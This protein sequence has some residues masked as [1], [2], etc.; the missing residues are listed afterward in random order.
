MISRE[1]T[2]SRESGRESSSR[3]HKQVKKPSSSNSNSS[4]STRDRTTE[5]KVISIPEIKKTEIQQPRRSSEAKEKRRSS[6]P[7]PESSSDTDYNKEH[8][9]LGNAFIKNTLAQMRRTMSTEEAPDSEDKLRGFF[10]SLLRVIPLLLK[11]EIFGK[12]D[13]NRKSFK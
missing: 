9:S 7:I 2:S 10:M 1:T 6:K 8:K 12:S 4:R 5:K 3:H 13:F 11:L